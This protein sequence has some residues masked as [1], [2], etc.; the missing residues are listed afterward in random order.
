[1]LPFQTVLCAL[2]FEPGS[3]RALVQ[4]A[5]LAERAHAALH[6]V[7]VNPLFRA[8]LAPT[9]GDPGA[10]FQ[11][12]VERF[13]NGALGA[14]DA[15]GVLAPALHETRGQA[16][17]DGIVGRAADVGADLV[18]VGTHGRGGLG[19]LLLG[20]VAAE[21]L[22]R[23]PV[24]VLVVPDRAEPPGAGRPVLVAVDEPE[25]AV[26]ALGFALATA[27]GSPVV[28]GHVCAADDQ[29]ER[30]QALDR[31]A[32]EAAGPTA[33]PHEVRVTQGEPAAEVAAMAERVGA[34]AV[35]MGTHGRTGWD[36][37]RLGSVAERTVRHAPCPVLTVPV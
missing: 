28:L 34:G 18:V 1:M 37:L 25:P 24:P 9:P 13:V 27:Y 8:R 20:S 36:R 2:D 15:F 4:A 29:G 21:T 22:R 35:V 7:H 31:L 14:D 12:R 5:D 30:R 32:A 33:P 6:L 16:P 11:E 3:E 26:V 10:A 23:S 17:A 19:H